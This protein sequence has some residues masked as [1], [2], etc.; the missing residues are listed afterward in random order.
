MANNSFNFT[1][2]IL[3]KII[4]PKAEKDSKGKVIRPKIVQH[5]YR[6]TKEKGLVLNVSYLGTKSFFLSKTINNT[7]YK[8]RLGSFHNKL[9]GSSPD[10]ISVAE[11]RTKA[12][13]LKNQLD[14]GI[15]P[16]LPQAQELQQEKQGTTFK[17]AFD[18]YINDYA[19]HNTK[20]WKGDIAE[21][22]NK[23]N[24]LYLKNI[25]SI[26]R[27]D[28]QKIFN[29]ITLKG[30]DCAN[31]FLDRLN[32]VFNK[33]RK[34]G[35]LDKNPTFGVIR[36]KKRERDRYLLVE[37]A[38]RFFDAVNEEPNHT[39]RDYILVSL[40][41][42]GRKSNVLAMRWD[43]ISFINK[44]WYT[45]GT[46]TKNGVSHVLPLSKQAMEILKVRYEQRDPQCPW[47]FPSDHNSKSGHLEE[48]RKAWKRILKR[49]GLKD[50]RLHDLRRT[51][52]SWM[53][54]AG[55][56]QYVIG[57]AL[58]HKSPNSTKIYARLNLDPVR[59]FMEKS[60]HIFDNKNN[61]DNLTI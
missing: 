13:K 42:A 51:R 30:T 58:N 45:P 56:S 40:H 16:T 15:N 27:D 14:Q 41:T 12:A 50:F 37:E 7:P 46:E 26:T 9:L 11:A 61:K 10:D 23:A 29:N 36:H 31:R 33:A 55:A 25:S 47:V 43:T 53:A 3:E 4:S 2:E 20:G 8:I 24:H 57:K 21:M 5:V 6:D 19:M 49:A 39:I 34:W 59:E 44:T 1:K 38:P 17:E 22:N 28:I 48:P 60:D 35:L 32:A 54:I 52:G 18:K